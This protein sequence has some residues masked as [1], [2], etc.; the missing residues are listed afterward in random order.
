MT[1]VVQRINI[2]QVL[3][4]NRLPPE[5]N[6][7]INHYSATKKPIA[8]PDK[9]LYIVENIISL[10]LLI[11]TIY[12]TIHKIDITPYIEFAFIILWNTAKYILLIGFAF[13]MFINSKNLP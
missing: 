2:P 11:G 9:H 1:T 8:T 3:F 10:A 7:I 5:L 6:R 12:I 13:A 4:K